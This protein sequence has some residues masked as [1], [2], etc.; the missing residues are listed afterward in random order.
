[1]LVPPIFLAIYF[2]VIF[3]GL[4]RKRI[5]DHPVCRKCRYDLTGTPEPRRT[6][7]ECGRDISYPKAILI[8]N[9][10]RRPVMLTLAAAMTMLPIV[11]IAINL[12]VPNI[13]SYKPLWLLRF[14]ARQVDLPVCEQAL[15]EIS[16]RASR[17]SLTAVDLS[18]LLDDAIYIREHHT[19][20]PLQWTRM[21]LYLAQ[22][23]AG[24]PQQEERF[25]RSY[26]GRTLLVRPRVR[27]GHPI[28]VYIDTQEPDGNTG[29]KWAFIHRHQIT[30]VQIDEHVLTSHEDQT[31]DTKQ[32]FWHLKS[33]VNADQLSPSELT[34][35]HHKIHADGPIEMIYVGVGG[36][37]SIATWMV[38]SSAGFELLPQDAPPTVEL[39]EDPEASAFLAS[40]IEVG[41]L[42]VSGRGTSSRSV[43]VEFT[44][45]F[46]STKTLKHMLGCEIYLDDGSGRRFIGYGTHHGPRWSTYGMLK[47]RSVISDDFNATHVDVVLAP[48]IEAGERTI[49]ITQIL[50]HKEIVIKDVAV[51][52]RP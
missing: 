40:T 48:S 11:W 35:G 23:R 50:N 17:G 45:P 22:T 3:L 1:M 14:E 32:W 28:P 37:R 16:R 46:G 42:R 34:P 13:H 44:M 6:C 38:K 4:R 2:V 29:S 25:A 19:H 30:Q 51:E 8:G 7:P 31:L 5:D 52:Y 41:T 47:T 26:A 21:T 33:T 10:R 20:W 49:D 18:G 39:V 27:R 43:T 15:R 36:E 9:R 12:S 24:T